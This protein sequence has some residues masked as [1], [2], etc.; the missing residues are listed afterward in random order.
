MTDYRRLAPLLLGL[1]L[2]LALCHCTRTSRSTGKMHAA[3]VPAAYLALGATAGPG[4]A[5]AVYAALPAGAAATKAWFCVG[6]V[7]T[8]CAEKIAAL[9]SAPAGRFV[10]ANPIKLSDGLAVHF[11]ANLSSGASLVQTVRISKSEAPAA[12]NAAGSGDASWQAANTLANTPA[13]AI[14]LLNAR[15]RDK[16]RLPVTLDAKLSERCQR[17]A[18]HM[19]DRKDLALDPQVTQTYERELTVGG[20]GSMSAEQALAMWDAAKVHAAA[21]YDQDGFPAAV[22]AGYAEYGGY[23]CLRLCSADTPRR[24]ECS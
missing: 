3:I 21:L 20:G 12:V 8:Q 2:L 18:K 23:A 16:G 11:N 22:K 24:G 14:E 1:G 17:W 15:R 6:A 9:P 7:P 4:D 5:Y 19:A 10:T 13:K